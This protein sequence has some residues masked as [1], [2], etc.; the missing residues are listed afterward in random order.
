MND[1]LEWML[2]QHVD[3][4][5][6]PV[7][8]EDDRMPTDGDMLKR[9]EAYIGENRDNITRLASEYRTDMKWLRQTLEQ[10]G[11]LL[12]KIDERQDK[13]DATVHNG[14]KD[15][16]RGVEK[17]LDTLEGC[18]DN[19]ATKADLEKHT[20]EADHRW[21]EHNAKEAEERRQGHAKMNR[22]KDDKFKTMAMVISA[23]SALAAAGMLAVNIF[24]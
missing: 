15:A 14:L 11:K 22:R 4:P 8:I 2:A 5:Y 18:V 23:L 1:D 20:L 16:M 21:E 13:I 12:A 7:A 10:H 6:V 24:L 19:T 9:H 17:R 3:S